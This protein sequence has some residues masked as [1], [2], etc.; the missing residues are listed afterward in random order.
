MV[1]IENTESVLKLEDLN[2]EQFSFSRI[3]KETE[4]GTWIGVSETEKDGDSFL[5]RLTIRLQWENT[6]YLEVVLCGKFSIKGGLTEENDYLK[7]NAVAIMF[8]YIR[9]EITLLTSQPGMEP[10]MLPPINV[11][12]LMKSR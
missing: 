5:M 9:S 1:K 8:P 12:A 3:K 4:N 11:N 7:S 10:V 2:F 6:Y